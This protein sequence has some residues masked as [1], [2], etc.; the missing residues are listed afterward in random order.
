MSS[1]NRKTSDSY[2]DYLIASLKDPEE[3]AAYLEAA[4]EEEDWEP[5]FFRK[6]L[7]N[8]AEALG[9][10]RLSPE[11]RK[12]HQEALE[13]ILTSS[14]SEAVHRLVQWL[15]EIGLKLTVSVDKPAEETAEELEYTASL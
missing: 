1:T 6:T 3:S 7:N 5:K 14:G 9:A 10:E 4:L 12:R 2:H 11:E 8:V 15:G 13:S